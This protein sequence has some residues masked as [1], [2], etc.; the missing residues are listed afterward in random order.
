VK[1]KQNHREENLIATTVFL[2]GS[3]PMESKEGSVFILERKDL[4]KETTSQLRR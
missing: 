3:Y 4:R 2:K 1:T